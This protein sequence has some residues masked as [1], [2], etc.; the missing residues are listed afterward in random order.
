LPQG[1][2]PRRDQENPM[3]LLLPVIL[4][5]VRS[6]RKGLRAARFI[7]RHLGNR[8]F[9]APLVDP[10]ELKLPLL[11]RMYKEYPKGEAPEM[12]ERLAGLFRRADAFVI[13]SAEYNHSIP[14]GLSNTLD[15]FLE[16][17]FWRPSAIVC[18][19]AGQFGG[20]RAAMQL[21]AMLS[22]LGMPSI[23]SLLPIPRIGTALDPEG[24]PQ[25]PWLD[26]A[27][28]RFVDELAWYAEAL[29]R[30]RAQGTPY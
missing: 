13:V 30:Q 25:E 10:V 7:I 16:E 29:S 23:P 5:S 9:E 26:K 18:Y 2:D 28:G 14:P 6:D 12:L 20:V 4:G 11:D 1:V 21:R 19:S 17:Y 8:G 3:P 15:H 24:T 22:E 27:A